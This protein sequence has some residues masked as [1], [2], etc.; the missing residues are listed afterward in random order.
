ME[1]D[2]SGGSTTYY[3]HT[4]E[5][6]TGMKDFFWGFLLGLCILFIPQIPLSNYLQVMIL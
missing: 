1:N 5:E 2:C 3:H 6:V 4:S